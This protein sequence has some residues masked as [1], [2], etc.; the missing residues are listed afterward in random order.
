MNSELPPLRPLIIVALISSVGVLAGSLVAPIEA[1]YLDSLTGDPVLTGSVFGIGSI[2]FAIFSYL[3]GKWSDLYG[4]KSFIVLGLAAGIVYGLAYPFVLNIFEIYGV[5]FAWAFAAIA[6]GP[7]ITGYL[8]DYLTPFANKGAYFG[9][10]YAAQS[11]SG[12]IGALLGG[13]IAE[14]YGI[15]APFYSVALAYAILTAIALFA[16]P[17][18]SEVFEECCPSMHQNTSQKNWTF[19]DTL[20]FL[21]R[22]PTL[23]FYLS[24]NTSFGINWGI[25]VFLWPLVIFELAQSDLITGSIFAT[26]GFIA[27]VLLPFAGRFV[28][29]WGPYRIMLLE[30]IVLG[31]TGV[32]LAL[33]DNLA[34]FWLLAGIYTIGE[35]LNGPAQGVLLTHEVRSGIRGRV[36]AL[37]ATMDQLLRVLSPF[38]AGFLILHLGVQSAFLVFMALFW[39]SLLTS[40]A[41]YVTHIRHRDV[42][43]HQ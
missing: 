20:S 5:K 34:V 21:C 7:L 31:T 4:R 16:L 29:R 42:A 9:Y 13:S 40:G 23:L 33:T 25:K 3:I 8:Q 32:G 15:S 18:L 35:V 28:D 41:L 6:T 19:F 27:F 24:V 26:M 10:V 22:T 38:A 37:D 14:T 43:I 11:I 39:L 17:R 12:S 2:F 30:L 1:R 36:V